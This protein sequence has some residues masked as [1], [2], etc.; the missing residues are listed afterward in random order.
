[1]SLER[2]LNQNE[3]DSDGDVVR[4]M[5]LVGRG[6]VQRAIRTSLRLC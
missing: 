4:K 6:I 1:M 5:G 3:G 2:V